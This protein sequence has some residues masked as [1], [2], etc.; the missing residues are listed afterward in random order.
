MY[1]IPNLK[2]LKQKMPSENREVLNSNP[3]PAIQKADIDYTC[4]RARNQ[5]RYT[6][7]YYLNLLEKIKNME[8]DF[9][10]KKETTEMENHFF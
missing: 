3:K 2:K 4:K 5:I 7:L 8:R 1:Y 10:P 6:P 9:F